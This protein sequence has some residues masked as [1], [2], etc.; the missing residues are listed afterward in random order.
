MLDELVKQIEIDPKNLQSNIARKSYSELFPEKKKDNMSVIEP[1]DFITKKREEEYETKK[2]DTIIKYAP[3]VKDIFDYY[4][5]NGLVGEENTSILQT[6]AAIK[7]L[8]FGIESLSGSGKSFLVDLLMDLLPEEYVYRI[9]LSSKTAEMYNADEINKAKIIYIPELQKALNSKNLIMIEVMKN[10]TEGR[11]AIRRVRNQATD[12]N[13]TYKI[14]AN[15]GIIYTLASENV[16]KKDVELSRRVFQLTTDS[17][18]EQNLKVI[19]SIVNQE[20]LGNNKEKNFQ[21]LKEHVKK[22]LDLPDFQYVNPF[23]QTLLEITP[24]TVKARTFIKHYLNLIQAS[25]KFHYKSRFSS[26]D[27]LFVNLEDFFNIYSLY[28]DLF[29][30][31][32][33]KANINEETQMKEQEKEKGQPEIV[34]QNIWKS[35]LEVMNSYHPEF[36]E[37]WIGA[38]IQDGKIIAYD[39]K[40]KR[41]KILGY[42]D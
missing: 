36:S 33:S 17:S 7:K 14:T 41:E 2:E 15:K 35:G 42:E 9:E 38:N 12:E 13:L 26:E 39:I 40:N 10:L 21:E 24:P 19:E 1:K 6:F 25:A 29:Y 27:K 5:S 32:V 4:E 31:G 16:F 18:T 34:W 37:K 11:D 30:K 22:C 3:S 20:Y 28:Q 23:S 8:N